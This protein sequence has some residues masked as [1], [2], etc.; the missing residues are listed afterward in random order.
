VAREYASREE[1]VGKDG[2]T[3]LFSCRLSLDALAD[4]KLRMKNRDALEHR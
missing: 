4:A 3:M 1:S 2:E